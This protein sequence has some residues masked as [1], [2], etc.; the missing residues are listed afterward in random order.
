MI[1]NQK[2]AIFVVLAGLFTS[3]KAA[4]AHHAKNGHTSEL[5]APGEK[6]VDLAG[7]IDKD[8]YP[9]ACHEAWEL[10][11]QGTCWC[12][13]GCAL[14]CSDGRSPGSPG[15]TMHPEW[16][17]DVTADDQTA[18]EE[19]ACDLVENCKDVSAE[20]APGLD[21]IVSTGGYTCVAG[22]VS[23]DFLIGGGAGG[24]ICPFAKDVDGACPYQPEADY[25]N[26]GKTIDLLFDGKVFATGLKPYFSSMSHFTHGVSGPGCFACFAID[27]QNTPWPEDW[28]E[29]FIPGVNYGWL[30]SKTGGDALVGRV[31]VVKK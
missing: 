26:G 6:P 5:I 18:C 4:P 21:K 30:T 28:P 11:T 2:Q 1:Y 17:K 3:A 20:L 9:P 23:H 8:K 24:A 13:T 31:T 7:R 25:V 27:G 15:K 19:L 10:F 12:F 16:C 14:D 29:D 22:D